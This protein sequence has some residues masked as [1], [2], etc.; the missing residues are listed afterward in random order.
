MA[1]Y[2][3][4]LSLLMEFSSYTLEKSRSS[5]IVH[6][7][8]NFLV[9][10]VELCTYLLHLEVPVHVYVEGGRRAGLVDGEAVPGGGLYRR[11]RCGVF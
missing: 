5:S 3:A 4:L 8:I 6:H 10:F 11:S 7:R 9:K 1:H 2:A